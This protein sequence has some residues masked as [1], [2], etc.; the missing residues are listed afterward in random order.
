MPTVRGLWL[1]G[2]TTLSQAIGIL[3]IR[4]RNVRDTVTMPF[5]YHS[6]FVFNKRL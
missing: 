1:Y 4:R 5:A 3:S 6:D 2:V